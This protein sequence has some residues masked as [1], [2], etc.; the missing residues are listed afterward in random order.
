MRYFNILLFLIFCFFLKNAIALE[1][2][3]SAWLYGKEHKWIT[4]I[5]NFNIISPADNKINYLF[6]EASIIHI[7]SEHKKLIMTYDFS[8]TQFYKKKLKNINILPDLSFWVAHTNFKYWSTLQYQQAADQITTYINNDPNADGVFLDL[9]SYQSSFLP[10]YQRLA[11]NLKKQHK[12]LSVIVAPGQENIA[13]FQALGKD[14]FV[15]LYGYDLHEKQDLAVPV[16][17]TIYQKRLQSAVAHVMKIA[18]KTHTRVMGGVPAIATTYEWEEKILDHTDSSKNLSN[19]YPQIDY[20]NAA[21]R[22]YEH[23]NSNLYIGYSIW[24]FVSNTQGQIYWP[25]TISSATWQR[26]SK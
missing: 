16:S 7:D 6:P 11:K 13:W 14:A 22:V 1:K 15:V 25:L 5:Q 26:L 12:I 9:E 18:E 20:L 17:P 2:G 24:A 10:F 19:P 3:N 23:I 4:Q 8:V 21:L